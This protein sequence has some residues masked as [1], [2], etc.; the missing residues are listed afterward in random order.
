MHPRPLPPP[1][2]RAP[3][4]ATAAASGCEVRVRPRGP[5]GSLADAVAVASLSA[6]SAAAAFGGSTGT[7]P[8]PTAGRT[9]FDHQVGRW[10]VL[11]HMMG[12][13]SG[14]AL[15]PE[16]LRGARWDRWDLDA[17]RCMQGGPGA[18]TCSGAIHRDGTGI[19]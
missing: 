10:H 8:P 14:G 12:S 1:L 4:P 2:P 19:A 6:A 15:G 17:L 16:W 3:Q 18:Y 9:Y 7:G 11:T 5:G 13:T